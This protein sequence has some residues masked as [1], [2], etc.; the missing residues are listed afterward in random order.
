MGYQARRRRNKRTASLRRR[1]PVGVAA[2]LLLLVGGAVVVAVVWAV[3]LWQQIKPLAKRHP[4]ALGAPSEVFAANG[5]PLGF[6]PS[7]VLRTPLASSRIPRLLKEATVAIE[8]QRFYRNDGIDPTSVARAAIADLLRGEP[9]QG[10]STITMQLVR[11]LYLGQDLKTIKQKVAEAKLALEFNKH[12]TKE[13][14]LAD[15]LND[16]TYGAVE[17]QSTIGVQAAALV[18][19]N[20]PVW[21]LD[22]QQLALLAGLPQAPTAYNP[23]LHPRLARQRRNE[24]LAKMA[25]LHYISKAEAKAAEAAPLELERGYY[26]SH[27]IEG[28]FLEY[29]R[30]E[31]DERYGEEVVADG[32]LKVY[33]TLNLEMQHEAR[34]AIEEVLPGKGDPAAAVVSVEPLTGYIR[35]MTES[36]QYEGSQFN[37]AADGHRQAGSTFK[38]FVL[39]T[40]LEEGVDPYTTYYPSEPLHFVDPRWGPINITAYSGTLGADYNI[41][42]AL[43]Q[44]NDPIFT[45]LDLDVGP[46]N[47]KRTAEEAGITAPL[48]GVPAEALGGLKVGVSPLEMATAYATVA[49]GGW[50]VRPVAVTKVVFPDGRV[51]EIGKQQPVKVFSNGITGEATKLLQQYITK[52]LGTRAYYGCPYAGGKTGTTNNNVDAWFV[53]FT[54]HLST[55]VWIGYPQGRVPMTD[56]EGL[57]VEG[58]NLPA[59]LWHDYME[60]ATAGSC[61]PFPPITEPVVY[62]PFH[63]HYM[64]NPPAPAAGI[65]GPQQSE[66]QQL[67]PVAAP[68]RP[69]AG[70][71]TEAEP[72][73]SPQPPAPEGEGPP[74]PAPS[75]RGG[76]A[77]GEEPPP[78]PHR[79][80]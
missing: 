73:P 24:V 20:K 56:V 36:P 59:E 70:A 75:R 64:A 30:Q 21:E 34:Q 11:N 44:S 54:A 32:G 35:A 9:I 4:L 76:V 29:V 77:P 1:G 33:T 78:R 3:A 53:G 61:E 74:P 45:L 17:G 57:T 8:D 62:K 39:L 14:I 28:F 38:L 63:G 58:P 12:H 23:F 13:E 51:E 67:P 68:A 80:R 49:D 37:L 55:A 48:E 71:G 60:R 41:A 10:A 47:V 15:Y 27:Q 31:L 6:L 16:V 72:R 26:Y 50:R 79:H 7:T 22:L 40:A 69:T 52:G 19:F 46:Q 43:M 66:G 65:G 2:A 5:T 42:T 18:F 25:E